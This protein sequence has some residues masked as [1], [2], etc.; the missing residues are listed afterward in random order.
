VR[1]VGTIPQY[2]E[3]TAPTIEFT[4]SQKSKFS[5]SMENL[6]SKKMTGTSNEQR[7]S[8]LRS[9]TMAEFSED[10]E[11]EVCDKLEHGQ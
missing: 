11:K 9:Q 8:L 7:Q 5:T 3:A 1:S 6:K 2:S 10:K 4:E